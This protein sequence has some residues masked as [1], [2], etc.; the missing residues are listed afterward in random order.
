MR[1]ASVFH[2]YRVRLRARLLQE[3]LAVAGI[4]VGVA[5]SFI[6][7]IA[8]ASLDESARAI[9]REFFGKADL[10]LAARGP[11]G[12]DER[13]VGVVRHLDGVVAAGGL[14]NAQVNLIGPQGQRSVLLISGN[15]SGSDVAGPAFRRFDASTKGVRPST[16]I[17]GLTAAVA[18]ALGVSP[19]DRVQLEVGRR[20]IALPVGA[21][22]RRGEYDRLA[23]LPMAIALPDFMQRVTDMR[24]RVSRIYVETAPGR[25]RDVRAALLDIATGRLEV[26]GPEHDVHAFERTAH[27]VRQTITPFSVF[28]VLI[29]FLLALSAV[30]LTVPQRRRFVAD[31]HLAGH[32]RWVAVELLLFD[33]LML[34]A[35]GSLVGLLAG[36]LAS[37]DLLSYTPSFLSYAFPIGNLHVIPLRSVVT[38]AAGGMAGAVLAVLLPMRDVVLGRGSGGGGS[39][40]GFGPRRWGVAGGCVTSALVT[41]LVVLAP[42]LGIVALF[43]MNATV[44]LFLPTALRG[45]VHGLEALTRR[46]RTPVPTLAALE[47]RSRSTRMRAYALAATGAIAV[48]A[49]VATAGSHTDVQRGFDASAQAVDGNGDVWVSFPGTANAYATTPLRVSAGTLA[50]VRALPG[51]TGVSAYHGSFLDIGDHRTLIQASSR[52]APAPVAASQLRQGAAVAANA[53]LRAGGWAVLSREIAEQMGVGLGD[54]FTLPAPIPTRLRVAAISTNLGWPP[55]VV[56]MNAGDYARA[57]GARVPSALQIRV[58]AGSS[59][60]RVATAVRRVLPPALPALVETQQ[61]RIAR[62]RITIR[63]DLRQLSQICIIVLIA[64]VIAMSGATAGMIWQRRPAIAAL[65]V[66]G[67]P[68]GELWLALLLESALLLGTGCLFGAFFGLCDQIVLTRVVETTT[69]FPVFYATAGL[70]AVATMLVVTAAAVAMLAL[71]GWLAVRVRPTPGGTM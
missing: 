70:T 53:R 51:V 46:M 18:D 21:L 10:Q 19:G 14:Q 28:A 43:V 31:L 20:S 66:H 33:A 50:D 59:P 45:A 39:H 36:A 8:N 15:R 52:S 25:S 61:M 5:L 48:F 41:A 71:P 6:A 34:G 4:A 7:L 49:T 12:I 63:H 37:R 26:W 30:L 60:E 56:V 54:R 16:R 24:G 62:H 32:E 44:L 67:Y 57:W 27:R 13:L 69:N 64:A 65:K 42:G 17:I 9:S 1:P 68:E 2:L 58:D 22:M 11:E 55:G 29:G 40:D 38:A 35:A 47:L 3:L 23:E